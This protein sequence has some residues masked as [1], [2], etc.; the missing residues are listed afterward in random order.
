M[1]IGNFRETTT[2]DK[3]TFGPTVMQFDV[4]SSFL[5]MEKQRFSVKA[6]TPDESKLWVRRFEESAGGDLNFWSEALSNHLL[7]RRGYKLSSN[8]PVEDKTGRSGRELQFEVMLGGKP[9]RY[10]VTLFVT[11]SSLFNANTTIDVVEL[12]APP[13]NNGED[14]PALVRKTGMVKVVSLMVPKH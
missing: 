5:V 7:H 14:L 2:R 13:I 9:K 4:P 11:P 3:L 8:M 10:V 1:A 6:I 12:I